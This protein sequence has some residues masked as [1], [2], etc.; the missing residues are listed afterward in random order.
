M[1]LM[2]CVDPLMPI[3][4]WLML[5]QRIPNDVE[6]PL[7]SPSTPL[8]RSPPHVLRPHPNETTPI[9]LSPPVFSPAAL[10]LASFA[11]DVDYTESSVDG[12]P[13]AQ[14]GMLQSEF[15]SPQLTVASPFSDD[16]ELA[17]SQISEV[18]I[19]RPGPGSDD[20]VFSAPS[21]MSS[22]TATDDDDDDS[23]GS[24]ESWHDIRNELS[25]F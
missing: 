9:P 16:F 10:P 2:R 12:T 13:P 21:S 5:L 19:S 1:C 7:L 15:T 4:P 20:E 17:R 6:Y 11:I 14:I 22:A 25:R 24:E 8:A 3:R 23:L 18:E